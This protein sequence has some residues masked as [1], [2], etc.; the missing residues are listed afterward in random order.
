[1]F[2]GMFSRIVH[3]TR[4]EN[5]NTRMLGVC[6]SLPYSFSLDR[7][8]A[9]SIS[10][11]DERSRISHGTEIGIFTLVLR[12]WSSIQAWTFLLSFVRMMSLHNL[13][14]ISASPLFSS[15]FFPRM[16]LKWFRKNVEHGKAHIFTLNCMGRVHNKRPIINVRLLRVVALVLFY[17]YWTFFGSNPAAS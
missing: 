1:M 10:G 4:R 9:Q 13:L 3:V 6:S 2:G 12:H 15:R 11:E 14:Y 5:G 7:N 16:E 17:V 8:R